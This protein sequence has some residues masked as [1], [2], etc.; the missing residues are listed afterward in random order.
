MK[1]ETERLLLRE[2]APEDFDA[3]YAVLS[4]SDI[5]RH[6]PY[7]FDE[8]R[9]PRRTNENMERYNTFGFGLWA[10]CLKESG[11]KIGNCGLTIRSLTDR[12][13]SRSATVFER[14]G[15]ERKMPGK[16]P[17]RCAIALSKTRSFAFFIF[18]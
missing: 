2:L 7:T 5:M 14:T 11:E 6:Y 8:K 4:D 10:V 9:V 18:T 15:K 17:Q 12:C 1:L 16:P 3:L 13:E